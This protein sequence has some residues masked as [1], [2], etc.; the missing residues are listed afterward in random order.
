MGRFRVGTAVWGENLV[1]REVPCAPRNRPCAC[2]GGVAA[3]QGKSQRPTG[4]LMRVLGRSRSVGIVIHWRAG[5]VPRRAGTVPTRRRI[6][7]RRGKIVPG[8][9]SGRGLAPGEGFTNSAH[10]ECSA[11]MRQWEEIRSVCGGAAAATARKLLAVPDARQ[12]VGKQL[13]VP[14]IAGGAARFH[15]E[16]LEKFLRVFLHGALAEL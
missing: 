16:F 1:R 4:W 5:K 2:R 14:P 3:A 6:V 10:C 7:R 11:E 13:F 8:K 15:P 12:F 9:G